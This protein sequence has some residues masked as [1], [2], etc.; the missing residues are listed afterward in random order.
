MA[1]L[2]SILASLFVYQVSA[3]SRHHL[4]NN[5]YCDKI[6][7]F[8]DAR[9]DFM[10][11]STDIT[12]TQYKHFEFDPRWRPYNC[13]KT[14]PYAACF[15]RNDTITKS[16]LENTLCS[17]EPSAVTS[18]WT[19]AL[20]KPLGVPYNPRALFYRGDQNLESRNTSRFSFAPR[21]YIRSAPLKGFYLNSIT[22]AF[23]AKFPYGE[24]IEDDYRARSI[25]IRGYKRGVDPFKPRRKGDPEVAMEILNITFPALGAGMRANRTEFVFP[26]ITP[27]PNATGAGNYSQSLT[28]YLPQTPI[29]QTSGR[30]YVYPPP[31]IVGTIPGVAD[32]MVFL[33]YEFPQ[34]ASGVGKWAGIVMLEISAYRER[35]DFNEYRL[36]ALA[37]SS[38]AVIPSAGEFFLKALNISQNTHWGECADFEEETY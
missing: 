23:A 36:P 28:T 26:T 8:R 13:P 37:D 20:R 2:I 1:T 5:G 24:R 31:A 30:V 3:W 11:N 27:M 21:Y 10:N 17:Y 12:S 19:S 29:F 22:I 4:A 25:V 32:P 14:F 15:I 16:C 9:D 38:R 6:L 18:N 33:R 34:A 7:N 35:V